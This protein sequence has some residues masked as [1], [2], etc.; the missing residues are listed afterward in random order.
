M[1]FVLDAIR[2]LSA[3]QPESTPRVSYSTTHMSIVC[4]LDFAVVGRVVFK[5]FPCGLWVLGLASP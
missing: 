5:V 2:L 4:R 1:S 3:E